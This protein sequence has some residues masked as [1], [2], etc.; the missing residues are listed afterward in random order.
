MSHIF[1]IFKLVT[2]KFGGFLNL[3]I[4]FFIFLLNSNQK[5][6]INYCVKNEEYM[7][8][9]LKNGGSKLCI[10][11]ENLIQFAYNST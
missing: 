7:F 4:L 2:L 10:I 11:V 8:I 5:K 9:E 6:L 3:P 1:L